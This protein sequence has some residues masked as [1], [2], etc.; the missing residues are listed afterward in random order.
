MV[1]MDTIPSSST[2][3]GSGDFGESRSDLSVTLHTH[4]HASDGLIQDNGGDDIN[5]CEIKIYLITGLWY[6]EYRG[7]RGW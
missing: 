2:G 7:Y 6:Y 5:T 1:A 4:A 3:A